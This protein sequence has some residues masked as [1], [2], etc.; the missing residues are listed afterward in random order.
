MGTVEFAIMAL[1]IAS[2]SP[3][4]LRSMTVSA[5]YFRQICSF[6]SSASI[7][8]LR[9]ELPIFALILVLASLPIAIGSKFS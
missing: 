9:L 1:L 5:P 4:V 6:S 8:L 2:R 7:S 3:P